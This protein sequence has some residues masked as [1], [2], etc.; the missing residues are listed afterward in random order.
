MIYLNLGNYLKGCLDTTPLGR[1]Y[2]TVLMA[3]ALLY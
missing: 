3:L 1:T 2:L